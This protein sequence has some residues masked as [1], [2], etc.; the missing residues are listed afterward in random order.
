MPQHARRL[1]RA[2]VAAELVLGIDRGIDGVNRPAD[3]LGGRKSGRVVAESWQELAG[4][5]EVLQGL[6][7]AGG[8]VPGDGR[9][10]LAL[11]GQN[12]VGLLEEAQHFAAIERDRASGGAGG[13]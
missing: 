10:M 8:H 2:Y 6:V 12:V 3:E 4:V 5:I 7:A 9:R 13:S 1:S 11:H